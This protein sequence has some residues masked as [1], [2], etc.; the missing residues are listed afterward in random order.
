M[1]WIDSIPADA[2][3]GQGHRTLGSFIG[4]EY[5][6]ASDAADSLA[7][8]I[9]ELQSEE[10]SSQSFRKSLAFTRLA[11]MDLAPILH[12]TGLHLI[13]PAAAKDHT[14]VKDIKQAPSVFANVIR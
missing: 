14:N 3:T 1:D 13:G 6:V 12:S 9:K 7:S 5:W 4:G 10:K 11:S 8:I 2:E